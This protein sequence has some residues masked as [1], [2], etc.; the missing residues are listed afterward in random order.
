MDWFLYDNGLRH[1]NGLRNNIES[2]QNFHDL[3]RNWPIFF[4]TDFSNRLGI[5]S[6]YFS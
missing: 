1:D 5:E 4:T 2:A 6:T 3:E